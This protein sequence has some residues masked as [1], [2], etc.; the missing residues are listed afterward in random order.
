MYLP[1]LPW[2][3]VTNSVSMEI[4]SLPH[5]PQHGRA[6]M[7]YL[8]E[9]VVYSQGKYSDV[10]LKCLIVAYRTPVSAGG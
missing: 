5:L 6:S 7:V 2:L 9:T 8:R 3:S 10:K 1:D 4:L